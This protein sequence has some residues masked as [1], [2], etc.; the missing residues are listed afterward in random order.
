MKLKDALVLLDHAPISD[1]P[2]RINPCLTEGQAVDIVL[3]AVATLGRPKDNPCG[4]EDDIHPLME[5]RVYQVA[6]NQKRPRY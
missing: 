1:K 5:E 6:R 4:P 3:K 2:S